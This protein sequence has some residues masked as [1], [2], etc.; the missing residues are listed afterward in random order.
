[1]VPYIGV[2]LK[3]TR[4]VDVLNGLWMQ[5]GRIDVLAFLV[6]VFIG[7]SIVFV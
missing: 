7:A 5:N 4:V 6:A 1:M 2:I 3:Y